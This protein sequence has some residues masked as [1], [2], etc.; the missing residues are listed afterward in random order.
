MK[1]RISELD[2]LRCIAAL[3]IVLFHINT[4]YP[5]FN[6]NVSQSI[7]KFGATGVDLF[8]MISGFVILLTLEKTKTW[9]DFVLR[10][11]ARLYPAYWVCVTI[12]ML[13]LVI[14][15]M[16][17]HGSYTALLHQY[18]PNLTMFQHYF[19]VPNIDDVY[20]TL[21]IEMLFYLFMLLIF[22]LK[23]L[24]HIE[25]IAVIVM[26]PLFFYSSKYCQVHFANF[27][28]WLQVILPL[29]NEFPLFVMGIIY[30]KMH[31]DRP[32]PYRYAA[33]L[34]C[35]LCQ[36]LLYGN[37]LNIDLFLSFKDY[38]FITIFYNL[39]FMLYLFGKLKFIVNRVTLFF[40]D[41]SYP[42]YLIHYYLSIK[43]IIPALLNLQAT[44]V[45][46]IGDSDHDL[47][48]ACRINF[49]VC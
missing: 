6:S 2:A 16:Y 44:I 8:F 18:L 19:R 13:G 48:C 45:A 26:L 1:K 28:H 43:V 7:L 42:L 25:Y 9:K 29:A 30:Y 34:V 40:G 12:T 23:Q 22:C 5:F 11:F 10:R 47:C 14:Y 21:I 17:T 24:K 27:H 46:G 39:V 32:T 4:T 41:I 3:S 35:I 37:G 20:W 15:L 36:V 49:E 38:V 31:F 33:L